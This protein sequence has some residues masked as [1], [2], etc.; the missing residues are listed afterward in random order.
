MKLK[1]SFIALSL[2][3][4]YLA[5]R[6]WEQHGIIHDLEQYLDAGCEGHYQGRGYEEPR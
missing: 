6:V 1:L 3:S 2:L 5:F 4:L